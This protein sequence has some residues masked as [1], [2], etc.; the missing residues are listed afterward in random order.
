MRRAELCST[1]DVSARDALE[2]ARSQRAEKG[3]K[4]KGRRTA[5]V[6]PVRDDAFFVVETVAGQPRE[7]LLDGKLV[8]AHDTLGARSGKGSSQ[9]DGLPRMLRD[10]EREDG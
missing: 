7:A 1:A 2:D 9:L 6:S 5:R 3:P 10:R 8:E 4:E